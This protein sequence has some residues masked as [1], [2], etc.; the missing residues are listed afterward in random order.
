MSNNKELQIIS[1]EVKNSINSFSIV[2]PSIYA[3]LFSK[4]A[5]EHNID[6]DNEEEFSTQLLKSECSNLVDLQDITSKSIHALDTNTNKAIN[7]IQSKDE[8][9]LQAVLQE[10]QA[11][12]A[13]VEKLKASVYNDELTKAF[14]RKWLHDNYLDT[15]G[16][17]FKNG[18]TLAIIDLNYFKQIN[19]THGHI[20]GDKVLVFITNELQ[21][22]RE[23][24]VRYGGDEFLILFHKNISSQKAAKVLEEIR[25]KIISKKLKSKDAAFKVSFSF[26]VIEFDENES[27]GDVI[28]KADKI[29]YEDK[30]RIKKKITGI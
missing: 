4:F 7:A 28:E 24:V 13:E 1:N 2:T 19:D 11:L 21:K 26:G 10:T 9:T 23:A 8:V 15:N 20:V 18:G 29:M 6:L 5:N 27:I 30:I 16:Q 25:T 17:N 12:R 14:N 3:S 22:I